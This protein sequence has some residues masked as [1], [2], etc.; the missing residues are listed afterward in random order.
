MWRRLRDLSQQTMICKNHT[1][2][3]QG[4]NPVVHG[5]EQESVEIDKVARHLKRV[6]CRPPS[7]STL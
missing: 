1:T 7:S 5:F 6:N 4:D 3:R 2:G